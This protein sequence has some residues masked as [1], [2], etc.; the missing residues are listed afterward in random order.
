[1]GQSKDENLRSQSQIEE[2]GTRQAL[3]IK[4]HRIHHERGR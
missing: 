2:Q 1:M 4:V 3:H